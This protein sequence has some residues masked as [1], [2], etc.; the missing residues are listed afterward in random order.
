[1]TS[2]TSTTT[3]GLLLPGLDG[4]NPLGFLAAL[5]TLR[6]LGPSFCMTWVPAAG[7]WV[8]RLSCTDKAVPGESEILDQLRV[9]LA[10]DMSEHPSHVLGLLK[11]DNDDE[12]R[13]LFVEQCNRAHKGN[14]RFADW[15]C[16]VGSDF[17]PP[18]RLTSC[19]PL[20]ETISY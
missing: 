12:R 3:D 13:Q 7:N 19:R 5:G 10:G 16:A 4:G 1:M 14:R 18:R 15:L 8:P 9:S 11:N 17:A 20:G 2:P 6:T